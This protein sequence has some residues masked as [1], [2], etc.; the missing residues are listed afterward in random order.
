VGEGNA[1]LIN[2]VSISAAID[3]LV[4]AVPESAV[5]DRLG[6]PLSPGGRHVGFG[7]RNFL[8]DLGGGAYLEVIGPDPGQPEP[9]RPRPFGI[10]S[11]TGPRLVGWAVRVTGIAEAVSR[12]RERGYDPGPVTAMSRRRPDGVLLEWQLTPSQPGLLP[13]LIDWGGTPHPSGD[14]RKG[15]ELVS[16]RGFHPSPNDVHKGLEALGAELDVAVGEPALVAVIRTP[17][18]EVVLR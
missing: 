12:A 16:L 17:D 1:V 7:T 11:L 13:F 9:G 14:A 3:H 4:Y 8:A 6:I 15:S 2:A 18:G 5:V 10:D